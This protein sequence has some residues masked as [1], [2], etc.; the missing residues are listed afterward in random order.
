MYCKHTTD[1]RRHRAGRPMTITYANPPMSRSNSRQNMKGICNL[2]FYISY[3][4]QHAI[5]TILFCWSLYSMYQLQYTGQ[6]CARRWLPILRSEVKLRLSERHFAQ[7]HFATNRFP[8]FAAKSQRGKFSGFPET[9]SRS[10]EDKEYKK[11]F[12]YLPQ[13]A[14]WFFWEECLD[15]L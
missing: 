13:I 8:K 10:S 4:I 9:E 14:T 1:K 12:P 11:P 6:F 2:Y 15:R 3:G 7:N 5:Q